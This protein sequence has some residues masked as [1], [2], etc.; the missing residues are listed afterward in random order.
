MRRARQAP[1]KRGLALAA[2]LVVTMVAGCTGDPGETPGN[3]TTRGSASA[4]PAQDVYDQH[5]NWS[6][7]YES[8]QCATVKVPLNWDK[9]DAD[10]IGIAVIRTKPKKSDHGTILV[11]PGGPG[12]S[13]VNIVK[14]SL[15]YVSTKR[16]QRNFSIAGFD[17]RGVGRSSAVD[18]F[19]DAERD[20]MRGNDA[21]PDT[22]A[23]LANLR[24]Q[25]KEFADAC[26]K[27]TGALLGH[28]DT[29]SA[30]R[31]MDVI[32]AAFGESTLNYLGFSYGTMLGS[33]YAE[34]YPGKVGKFVLDGAL[35]PS[36]TVEQITL[37]QAKGFEREL[38]VYARRCLERS[39]CPLSGSVDHAVGQ[40]QRLLTSATANP[41][42][43]T[44]GR[45]VG[46]SLL[47]AGILAALY[48]TANW[49]YLT[50]GLA[51]AMGGDP[52]LL[53]ALADQS[54]DR[55]ESGHYTSNGDE[56]F[57]AINCLDYSPSSDTTTM[58]ANAKKVEKASPTFGT[59]LAYTGLTC[60]SWPYSATNAPAPARVKGDGPFLVVGTTGDPAT[61]YAWSKSLTKQLPD[62]RLLTWRGEGHTAYGRAGACINSKVDDYFLAGKLP[63]RGTVCG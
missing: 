1:M 42:E 21:D 19:T 29:K 40:I 11:D 25:Y 16:L 27:N 10:T 55:D 62:A 3:D 20:R 39:D 32:R 49:E 5:L 38:R 4:S 15:D 52:G 33:T 13:G 37:G 28:V 57:I 24:R 59:A 53:L 35:D 43:A 30:A 9:P 41:L 56:A 61:P 44:D 51:G 23:G 58:R 18:C 34:L 17:P 6:T 36:L 8:F 14:N 2:A 45:K 47:A 46:G 60:S 54:A 12:G 48:N 22:D 63:A 26:A 50:Q 7:C 31:D